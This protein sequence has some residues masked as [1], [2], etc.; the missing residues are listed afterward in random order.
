TKYNYD[1]TDCTF[2]SLLLNAL[3][4][5]TNVAEFRQLAATLTQRLSRLAVTQLRQTN[6]NS[7][8][9]SAID[10]G[11]KFTAGPALIAFDYQHARDEFDDL[12][13]NTYTASVD[14]DILKSSD[15]SIQGGAVDAES[16][17]TTAFL[18]LTFTTRF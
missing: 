12:K 11:F 10:A 13:S 15:I 3:L 1:D 17:G 18:G 9:S 4:K 2:D 6:E 5:R 16:I 14:F 7:F 8:L